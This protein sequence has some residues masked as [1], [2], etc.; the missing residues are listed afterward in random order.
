MRAHTFFWDISLFMKV[1]PLACQVR[2]HS[3]RFQ[4]I[5]L[6]QRHYFCQCNSIAAQLGRSHSRNSSEEHD[7]QALVTSDNIHRE[8][9]AVVLLLAAG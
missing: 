8:Q 1:T 7:T 2:P 6:S 9:F 4:G 5:I 3:F